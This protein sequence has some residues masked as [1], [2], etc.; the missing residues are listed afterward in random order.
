MRWRLRR[1]GDRRL[2]TLRA[3]SAALPNGF[4]SSARAGRLA[5]PRR[6]ERVHDLT[7][8]PAAELEEQEG[9]AVQRLAEDVVGRRDVLAR[10][11]PVRTATRGH[12]IR[13][14]CR[15]QARAVGGEG[16]IDL[17]RHL[18]GEQLGGK[19]RPFRH[20]RDRVLQQGWSSS[21]S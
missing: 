4:L 17:P 21:E 9:I 3:A 8:R 2:A 20:G 16:R 1:S 5:A 11:R 12:E 13:G 15:E 14:P 6:T 7:L 10:V 18:A 19:T